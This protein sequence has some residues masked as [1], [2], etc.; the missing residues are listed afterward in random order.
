MKGNVKNQVWNIVLAIAFLLVT[1]FAT[2]ASVFYV[3]KKEK[4][5]ISASATETRMVGIDVSEWNQEIDWVKVKK[6]GVEFAIIRMFGHNKNTNTYRIDPYFERNV[7]EA[8][9]QGIHLGAYFFSYAPTL[10]DI[11]NEAN[12]VVELLDK[13]PGVFSF[14]I[15]FDAED[16]DYTDDPDVSGNDIYDIGPFAGDAAKNFCNILKENGYYPMVYSYDYYFEAKIGM[17]KVKDFDLWLAYYPRESSSTTQIYAGKGPEYINNVDDSKRNKLSKYDENVTMWQYTGAGKIDGIY[18]GDGGAIVDMNVCYV[19]YTK[20]IPAGGYNGY[21]NVSVH[22]ESIKTSSMAGGSGIPSENHNHSNPNVYLQGLIGSV[23]SYKGLENYG[24]NKDK[25]LINGRTWRKWEE[26]F[27]EEVLKTLWIYGAG[28]GNAYLGVEINGNSRLHLREY[29]GSGET[30][31]TIVLKKGFEIVNPSSNMWSEGEIS[32]NITSNVAGRVQENIILVANNK[33]GF[34]VVEG[35]AS[36]TL[37]GYTFSG[38]EINACNRDYV[39]YSKYS[40]VK[41]EVYADNSDSS[42]I[43]VKF[44]NNENEKLSSFDLGYKWTGWTSINTDTEFLSHVKVNGTPIKELYP[45]IKF[46]AMETGNGL[47]FEG[48]SL[49]AGDEVTIERGATHVNGDV[50]MEMGYKYTFTFDGNAYSVEK[51]NGTASVGRGDYA[52][53]KVGLYEDGNTTDKQIAFKFMNNE[54]A[55]AS[56]VDLGYRKNGWTEIGKEDAFLEDIRFNGKPIKEVFPEVNLWAM[57]TGN[58]LA[59]EGIEIK[60]GDVIAIEKGATFTHRNYKMTMQERFAFKNNGDSYAYS[61]AFI[62]ENENRSYYIVNADVNTDN[63]NATQLAIELFDNAEKSYSNVDLGYGKTNWTKLNAEISFLSYVKVNGTP[64]KEAYPNVEFWAFNGNGLAFEKLELTS[65]DK[66]TI[67]KGAVFTN[68]GITAK[69]LQEFTFTFNGTDYEVS[70]TEEA[71][72][73]YVVVKASVIGGGNSTKDQLAFWCYNSEDE[74][75]LAINFG[76]NSGSWANQENTSFLS[77]VYKNGRAIKEVCPDILLYTISPNGIALKNIDMNAGDVITI[78]EKGVF[79]N[80][81]VSIEMQFTFTFT[82]DGETFEITRTNETLVT[83]PSDNENEGEEGNKPITPDEGEEGNKPTTPDEGEGENKPATP[84]EGNQP[85]NPNQ[86]GNE[87]SGEN[88]EKSETKK[89]CRSSVAGLGVVAFTLGTLA[90]V[91]KKKNK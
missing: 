78:A 82:F 6:A 58:G 1:L 2:L 69:L 90:F 10:A 47:S 57:E 67:D 46:W 21:N 70:K 55:A 60:K 39:G 34:N 12:M 41:A 8:Q 36:M 24:S 27:G 79:E 50:Q 52:I 25:I 19:D 85:N 13:Y 40:L 38:E 84:N 17:E 91:K 72:K 89:G 11:T 16:G 65:G 20:I 45:E 75:G 23:N 80:E 88:D 18:A 76:G 56:T 86:G 22:E 48:M 35:D 59:L 31:D 54:E 62:E 4:A 28:S 32:S 68:G 49:S 73:E 87:D 37:D 74:S 61:D 63:S 81:T 15:V 33:G 43:S 7:R 44:L 71:I 83:P 30:I 64:I 29:A 3:H 9:A 14:P 66:V 5:P 26:M 51:T 53:V 77:Y 42:K